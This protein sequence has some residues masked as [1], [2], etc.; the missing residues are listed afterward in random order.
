M[1]SQVVDSLGNVVGST[2]NALDINIK[3]GL[4]HTPSNYLTDSTL[5]YGND[6]ISNYKIKTNNEGQIENVVISSA[7]PAGAATETTL[8]AL[9]A[10]VTG[11]LAIEDGNLAT[12]ASDTTS[13]DNKI[14]AVA[15]QS[16]LT[17]IET[18]LATTVNGLKVDGTAT[19]QPITATAMPLP[20]LASTS[21]LQGTILTVS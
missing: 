7:L 13:L 11:T 12:I 21:T 20:A 3:S 18:K 16:T 8:A 5:I 6:S 1:K 15:K 19:V 9:N 10:K 4:T 14:D 2:S 17:N